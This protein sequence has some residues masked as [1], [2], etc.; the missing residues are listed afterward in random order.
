MTNREKD[1]TNLKKKGLNSYN[2]LKCIDKTISS[3][4]DFLWITSENLIEMEIYDD[5]S[6]KNIAMI[7]RLIS[8]HPKYMSSIDSLPPRIEFMKSDIRFYIDFSMEVINL[9]DDHDVCGCITYGASRFL[10]FQK[11]P[12]EGLTCQECTIK[13]RCD[14]LEDKPLL[15]IIVSENGMLSQSEFDNEVWS[16]NDCKDLSDL[17]FRVLDHVLEDA[18]SFVNEKIL[19]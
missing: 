6:E 5:E 4:A 9:G 10:C 1:K 13:L 8:P 12:I 19:P 16:F 18:F 3:I 11:C 17:H 15:K 14:N 7:E 2:R